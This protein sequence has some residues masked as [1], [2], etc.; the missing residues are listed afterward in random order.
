ME[1]LPH[2][3]IFASSERKDKMEKKYCHLLKTQLL[4]WLFWLRRSCLSKFSVRDCWHSLHDGLW[5][6]WSNVQYSRDRLDLSSI[7]QTICR[8]VYLKYTSLQKAFSLVPGQVEH[9][10]DVTLLLLRILIIYLKP[11]KKR[12]NCLFLKVRLSML[13][14]QNENSLPIIP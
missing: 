13:V 4:T 12:A 14:Q 8:L 5:S 11:V 3:S 6:D 1:A 9:A 7:F 2:P 10:R